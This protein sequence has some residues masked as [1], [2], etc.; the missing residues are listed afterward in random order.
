M[1]S[2]YESRELTKAARAAF[3]AKFEREVDPDGVLPL[4]ERRRRAE[5]ARKAH[6]ARLAL[7]SAQARRTLARN[8]GQGTGGSDLTEASTSTSSSG[9]LRSSSGSRR[10][11][12]LALIPARKRPNGASA[13]CAV[14][15]RR[16]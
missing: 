4:E 3:E 9:S 5:M 16:R 6:Y 2:R 7:A 15:R 11:R 10:Q 13:L 12:K 1:H 8:R 14:P